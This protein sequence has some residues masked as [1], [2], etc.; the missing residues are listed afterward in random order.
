MLLIV[1]PDFISLKSVNAIE[2]NKR[3]ADPAY[4]PYD[5]VVLKKSLYSCLWKYGVF[6]MFVDVWFILNFLA[7]KFVSYPDLTQNLESIWPVIKPCAV[8]TSKNPLNFNNVSSYF[9]T[10]F[11]YVKYV[12]EEN[13]YIFVLYSSV[14][15]LDN[16]FVNPVYE[17][18]SLK[19]FDGLYC[20]ILNDCW[21]NETK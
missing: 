5:V 12:S 20:S 1:K 19:P 17:P 8:S 13:G 18:L 3:Y 14:T 21:L 11:K 2:F 9:V 10:P 4:F 16:S 6:N 15:T 7:N